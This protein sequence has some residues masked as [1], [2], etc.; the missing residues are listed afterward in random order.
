MENLVL[1]ALQCVEE[2][3]HARPTMSKVVEML[4]LGENNQWSQL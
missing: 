2:D 3:R 1:I 4:L